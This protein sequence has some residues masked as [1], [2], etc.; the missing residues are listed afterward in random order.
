VNVWHTLRASGN[1]TAGFFCLALGTLVLLMGV[2]AVPVQA[3]HV[4]SSHTNNASLEGSVYDSAGRPIS[5]ALVVLQGKSAPAPREMRTDAAGAFAYSSLPAGSY[6]ISATKSGARSDTVPA[7][8]LTGGNRRRVNLVIPAAPKR[9]TMSFSDDPNFTIAGVTDWT[10]VGG[11]GSDSILRT[12]EDLARE[13]LTL[14]AQNATA[15]PS[16]KSDKA[17]ERQLRAALATAPGSFEANR[18]LA[19]FYLNARRESEALPLLEAA[20]RLDPTDTTNE[21]DLAQAYQVA[22]DWKRAREHV[23]HLLIRN[24][25]GDLHRMAADLD[26]KLGDPLAAVKEYRE[27]VRLEPSEQNYLA[28][29]SELLLHR[30]VWQATEV[31]RNGVKAHPQSARLLTALGTALFAGAVYDEAAQ[32]LCEASDLEPASADPYLFMGKVEMAAPAALP[33]I[34]TRLARFA[35]ERPDNSLANYF[36]AMALL[37]ANQL[38]SNKATAERVESL[39]QKAV[40]L[41]AKCSDGYLQLGIL[42]AGQHEYE[43]AIPLYAKAIDIDP[44]LSEAHYRLGVAYDRLGERDKAEREFQLHD[45]LQER[46]AAAVEQERREVKQFVVVNGQPVNSVPQ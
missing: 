45:E 16:V 9:E 1:K 18:E 14:E 12:S 11:H 40:A 4:P 30:A 22:G 44:Q 17:R 25:D 7:I 23:Q 41:D 2:S 8:V 13:T 33:C 32:R 3:Q 37:K 36:Y 26:E 24:H 29:G 35:R 39:L 43:R 5:N 15:K 6:T 42:A 10:A 20:Y 27:A 46:Q 38:S 34:E 28:W 31:F 21:R 19:I